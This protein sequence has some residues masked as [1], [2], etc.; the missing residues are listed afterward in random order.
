[1]YARKRKAAQFERAGMLSCDA[2]WFW[3][4]WQKQGGI[5][6]LYERREPKVLVPADILT[7]LAAGLWY[8]STTLT[9]P[10]ELG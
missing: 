10:V 3:Q 1:M 9:V 2:Q 5:S 8:V 6:L 4:W 7:P